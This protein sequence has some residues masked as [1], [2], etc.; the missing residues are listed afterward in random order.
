M[1]SAAMTAVI[2]AT[3]PNTAAADE[4]AFDLSSQRS[5]VQQLNP[6]PG[7]KID[8][9]G[10]IINPTPHS[11]DIDRTSVYTLP[12]TKKINDK[13]GKFAY[14]IAEVVP[15]GI[16]LSIDFGE[17]QAKKNGVELRPEAYKL[18][19]DKKGVTITGYDE[20]GAFYG[21]QTLRQILTSEIASSGTIPHMT[22]NDWPSLSRRGVDRKSVV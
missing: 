1:I 9:Q 4:G 16:D 20:A 3:V 8:H 5:E 11:I 19:V 18:T 13:K 14:T 21:L 22:I 15:G 12:A 10:L 7:K 17:K 2:C 6:V